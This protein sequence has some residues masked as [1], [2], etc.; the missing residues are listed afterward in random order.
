MKNAMLYRPLKIAGLTV[1]NRIFSAPTSLAE[2]SPEGHLTSENI[3]YYKLRAAGG[4]AVVTIGDAIVQGAA[5]QSHPNQILLDDPKVI[6]SLTLAADAIHAHNAAASIELDH[7]GGL[8]DPV[9]VKDGRPRGPSDMTHSW[10]D[11]VYGL[12]VSEIEEIAAAFGRAAETV[13]ACGF[14]MLMIHGGHGWLLHQFLSPVTNIRTDE[15]GGSIENRMRFSLLVIDRVREAVGKDFPI[16]FRMS[17]DERLPPEFGGYGAETGLRIAELLDGKVDLIH[18]SVGNNIDW[19]SCMLMHPGCFTKH[20]ENSAYAAEIRR[21][22]KTPVVSVGAFTDVKRMEAFLDSGGADAIALG[23]ALIADP[24]LPK[25][26]FSGQEDN[27]T[28]CLR[29]GE[30]QGSMWATRTIRCT[31]NPIIG[32]ESEYFM[33]PPVSGQKKKVLIAGGGPAGLTAAIECA[34]RGHEVV[35]CESGDKLGGALFFAEGVDFKEGINTLREVLVRRAEAA[36]IDIRLG[37]R[38]DEALVRKIAPDALIA[39]LGSLPIIPPIPGADGPQVILGAHV[40]SNTPIGKRVVLIGGG[41]VGCETALELAEKGHEV[42]IIEMR[43]EIAP[44]ANPLHRYGLLWRMRG[45]KNLRSRTGLRC[46]GIEPGTVRAAGS[47]GEEHVF[48]ADSVILAAGLRAD[49]ANT[50]TLRGLVPEFY[51]IGDGKQAR[52]ILQAIAEGYAAAVDL[53]LPPVQA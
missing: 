10:G 20:G 48:E 8:C 2:L 38:V 47:E 14:D 42:D 30:C 23:R 53:S 41:L 52:R 9:F 43:D 19:E 31:V 25:K 21:R 37:T 6:P 34:K 24:F 15:Y 1:K 29:C 33:P 13:K 40:R 3:L 44:E 49:R 26:T 4:C 39:A 36:G 22:V 16:E 28:P 7:G 46:T 32:R 18:V 5:G 27:V 50:E 12:T 35:L 51:V 11:R 45:N 17:A